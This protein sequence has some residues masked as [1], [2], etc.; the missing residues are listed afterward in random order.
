[1]RMDAKPL[2]HSKPG[3]TPVQ[4]KKQPLKGLTSLQFTCETT[5]GTLEYDFPRDAAAVRDL[6]AREL[7]L[8]CR[9]CGQVHRFG[10]RSA[11]LDSA[12]ATGTL[13]ELVR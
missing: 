8:S 12:L 13:H 6:W 4:G 9:H 1:M 5:G 10:F 7:E 3:G 11:F 2:G